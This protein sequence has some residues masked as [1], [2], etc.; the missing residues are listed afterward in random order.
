MHDKGVEKGGLTRPD[1]MK[2]KKVGKKVGDQILHNDNFIF[3]FLRSGVSSQASGW[4]DF[5]VSFVFFAWV[6]L[7]AWLSTAIG[8]VAGGVVNCIINYRFTF[9]AA[10]LDWRA[11]IVKY[12]LVWIGSLLLNSFGSELLFYVIRDWDWLETIGFKHDG[13]FAAARLFVSLVVSWG[14]NFILQRYFV[15]RASWFDEYA[16]EFMS[17]LGWKTEV[18]SKR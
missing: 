6:N 7:S 9:H 14:W 10:G 5:A 2:I 11:I 4:T 18:S 13:Y 17:R 15:Y 8:A 1:I 3:T 12:A 16:I